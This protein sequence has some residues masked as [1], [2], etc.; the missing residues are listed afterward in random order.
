SK[1]AYFDRMV[2]RMHNLARPRQCCIEVICVD[3]VEPG[4][5]F[6][7]LNVRPVDH[8]RVA[9]CETDDSSRVGAMECATEDECTT[10]LHIGFDGSDPLHEVLHILW[11]PGSCRG[12]ACVRRQQILIHHTSS[13]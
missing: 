7:R 11:S 8:D 1:W 6:F 12:L 10:G 5:M 4:D 2:D 13:S 9:L 3:D